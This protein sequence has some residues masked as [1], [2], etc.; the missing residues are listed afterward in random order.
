MLLDKSEPKS[1]QLYYSAAQ[2]FSRVANGHALL[3]QQT[4]TLMDRA[5]SINSR[6]Y[7]YIVELGY[8]HLMAGNID[9]ASK[10]FK[11]GIS[12]EQTSTSASI[13]TIHCLLKTGQL[14]SANQ[15][16]EFLSEVVKEE[17]LSAVSESVLS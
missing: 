7:G 12:F 15:Q 2:T 4:I 16:L 11:M 6:S 14:K 5:L 17:G 8:Q 9:K 10:C 13:G 1:H 3:L